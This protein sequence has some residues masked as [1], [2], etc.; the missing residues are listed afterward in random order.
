MP[1]WNWVTGHLL[2]AK[3]YMDRNPP[4]AHINTIASDIADDFGDTDVF[5]LDFWP[6]APAP[7]LVV[8]NPSVA[9]E[10]ISKYLLPKPKLFHQAFL[11]IT[12]G[13]NLFTMMDQEWKPWRAIFN[14]GFSAAAMLD[15]VPAIVDSVSI[16]C[17]HLQQKASSGI[18]ELEELTLR[19]T[20][21][22]IIKV[23]LS[24]STFRSVVENVFAQN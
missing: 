1:P 12:G 18:F 11:A 5:L 6:F 23:S 7:F 13:P 14:P 24:V 9:R 15:Q 8:A 19:L 10:A 3:I 17:N 21:D 4:D 2:A 22:V 20:M 16:F